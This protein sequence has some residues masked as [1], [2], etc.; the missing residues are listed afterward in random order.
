[1]WILSTG[2]DG[3]KIPAPTHTL[4]SPGCG[5]LTERL[6]EKGPG[7]PTEDAGVTLAVA[8]SSRGEPL[9]PLSC[10]S[11]SRRRTVCCT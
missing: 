10:A 1:M 7:H 8:A 6:P 9:A 11:R 2:R 4:I 3:C 5:A